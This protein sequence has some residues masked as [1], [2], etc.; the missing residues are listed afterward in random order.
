M[1][2]LGAAINIVFVF[3][4]SDDFFDQILNRHQSIDAA[5]F[6]HHQGHMQPVH[7]HLQ[8]QI[9][10]PHRRRNKQD[11]AHHGTDGEIFLRLC[12]GGQNILD[13]DHAQH[14]I[15]AVAMHRIARMRLARHDRD[16]F[17]QRRIRRDRD[18]IRPGYHHVIGGFFPDI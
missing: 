17:I 4:F 15:Q 5:I 6:I 14:V 9:Q 18:D 7:A 8:Q 10:H 2:N 13:M 16:Q 3:D 12:R 11:L 1:L